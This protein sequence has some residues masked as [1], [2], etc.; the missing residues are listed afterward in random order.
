MKKVVFIFA[1]VLVLLASLIFFNNSTGNAI[2]D[3]NKNFLSKI[4]PG[5]PVPNEPLGPP[6]LILVLD[7][8]DKNPIEANINVY[9][10]TE[11]GKEGD[12]GWEELENP[13]FSKGIKGKKHLIITGIILDK[14]KKSEEFIVALDSLD[15]GNRKRK[16][17]L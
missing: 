3:I 6:V 15:Y 2:Y 14:D 13:I 16:V 11:S 1:L 17:T 9:R 7:S 12:W 5:K 10:A 8:E 4:I